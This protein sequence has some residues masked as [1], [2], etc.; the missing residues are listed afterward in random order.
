M[1]KDSSFKY[2]RKWEILQVVFGQFKIKIIE[3]NASTNRISDGP[4][5]KLD[6]FN[7]KKQNS[8]T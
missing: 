6:T 2:F 5:N 3:E 4:L 8:S 7:Y 1:N